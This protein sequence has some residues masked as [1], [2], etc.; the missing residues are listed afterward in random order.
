MRIGIPREIKPGEGR[1]ALSPAGARVLGARGHGVVV[2]SSAGEASGFPDA[3]Y[4]DVGATIVSE[5]HEA[6]AQDLVLKVKEPLAEE[7]EF[8]R[9]D[10]L[11]FS[12]LHLAA[13]PELEC[14]LA[15]AG[16]R[17][18]AY[19]LVTS[20][21]GGLPLLQPMSEIAGRLAMQAGARA[22]E[23]E[24]GGCGLLVSGAPGTRRAQALVLGGGIVGTEAARMLI[25]AGARVSI[26][27]VSVDRLRELEAQFGNQA[28][29]L[30]STRDELEQ[31]LPST[32]LLIGAVLRSG[33]RTPVLVDKA[34]VETMAP[35]SAIVDVAV[36]QGGCVASTRPTTHAD[37]TYIEHGVV[38]SAVANMP[39]A[40]PRTSTP[41]LTN[42]TLDYVM[43]LADAGQVR[44]PDGYSASL[45]AA[46]SSWD[47]AL[48]PT[49]TASA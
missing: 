26:L 35:G 5:A 13:E 11:L 42:A 9:S 1:V 41:A 34:L 43:Q 19:E 27:D 10:L 7:W 23:R 22:L 17:A 39:G 28:D 16:V 36:D 31:R 33:E 40:V 21:S 46:V 49:A 15:D 6:W 4:A 45:C 29:Y 48:A 25:G 18:L 24:S 12:Y 44:A 2:Q 14:A 47:G 30:Y 37:P 38:H 3:A 32:D 8:F 20:P